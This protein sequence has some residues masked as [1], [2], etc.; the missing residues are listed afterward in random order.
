MGIT[1]NDIENN[2]NGVA[3][4]DASQL[5]D[6]LR[7]TIRGGSQNVYN[8]DLFPDSGVDVG[9]AV[10]FAINYNN[11][12]KS[13]VLKLNLDVAI[14]GT[15][16]TGVWEYS[17][18]GTNAIPN[19]SA[20]SIISDATNGLTVT[21]S[22]L[23]SFHIPLD[24]DNFHLTQVDSRIY[25]CFLVRYRIT[26]VTTWTEGGHFANISSSQKARG[27]TINCVGFT[28]GSPVTMAQIKAANDAGGWGVVTAVGNSYS[29]ACN[30]YI[31]SSSFFT[32][33]MESIQFELNWFL[34]GDGT[35]NLGE[36]IS[37]DKVRRGSKFSFLGKN[38]NYP[39]SRMTG[40]NSQIFNSSFQVIPDANNSAGFNGP[41]GNVA[42]EAGTSVYDVYIESFR[43]LVMN[44]VNNVYMGVKGG[45]TSFSDC[46]IES[47]GAVIIDLTIAGGPYAIR[48]VGQAPLYIHR[49]DFS[50]VTVSPINPYWSDSWATGHQSYYVDC[51]FGSFA[52]ANKAYWFISPTPKLT[53]TDHKVWQTYSFQAR[54]VDSVGAPLPSV[55][56]M[57]RNADGSVHFSNTTSPDGYIS[58]DFGTATSGTTAVLNDTSKLW[59]VD[60]YFYKEILL[61]S[62]TGQK[63]RRVI[64]RGG[65]ATQLPFAW[66][67]SIAPASGTKYV[68]IP[69]VNA[70]ALS[71]IAIT[72]STGQNSFLSVDNNPFSMTIRK[73]GK[74]F[75]AFSLNI[76]E[77]VVTTY[78]AKNNSFISASELTA[79]AYTGI[80]INGAVKTINIT[81]AH[82][83]QEVYDYSQW[84]A[85]Q[86]AN[87]TYDEPIT[88]TDGTSFAFNT[89]WSITIDGVLLDAAGKRIQLTGTGT[90]SFLNGAD[91]EGVLADVTHTHVK[92]TA[93]NLIDGTRVYLI[94]DTLGWEVDNDVVSGGNG[95]VFVAD[96][97]SVQLVAGNTIM[98]FATYCSGL[99]AKKELS[100]TGILT[101]AGLMFID[102]QEDWLEYASIG[103]DGSTVTEF[104]ADYP[105]IEVNISDADNLTTKQRLIAWWIYNLST[106]NGIRFFFEG[107][108]TEDAVNYRI[109]NGF[110]LFLDN[111]KA[112]PLM[113]TDQARL[114]KANG[115]TIIA[116]TSNSIQ[117]DSGKVY[118]PKL[119]DML[120]LDTL[121]AT[122]IPVNV[123]KINSVTVVGSGVGLDPWGGV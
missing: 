80:A 81:A 104:T 100:A 22:R 13:N 41:W 71:P 110:N 121:N 44:N 105:M 11:C 31:E 27:Y 12:G 39:S 47:P 84:W 7:Y 67:C 8:V 95:Y 86:P 113:F 79:G 73:Y 35:F 120:T 21:G 115:A 16:I 70:R 5:T 54:V 88:T 26:S 60:A 58:P 94:N 74:E 4:Y 91:I 87:M 69:Y 30:L 61:T 6:A 123:K 15:G 75:Q 29:F 106:A 85:S 101:T 64:K 62:G 99:V 72:P 24:W 36:I 56:V 102:S 68:I 38:C 53:R 82:T 117:L 49:S 116:T 76:T 45:G 78:N 33:K 118:S 46:H 89:D 98:L 92:I 119:D 90:Y 59:A 48:P 52:D 23:V 17:T 114:Y 66:P 63:Q 57:L 111:L 19:W 40:P 93:P 42:A 43:Q 109:N 103:I 2:L 55:N 3:Y 32:S 108:T 20:L 9:D 83:W 25:Y 1:F 65:T 97:P 18:G 34:F 10:I 28:S 50:G 77:A 51:D 96:I 107:I 112:T 122:T 14:N 37:G